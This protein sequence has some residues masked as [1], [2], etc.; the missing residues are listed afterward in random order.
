V[1]GYFAI[2]IFHPKKSVNIGSLW[3]SAS[4]FG[5]SYIFTIGARYSKQ[6]S[7][8]MKTARH[9]P[10]HHYSDFEDFYQ[11]MPHDARVVAVEIADGAR[12]LST[13]QHPERAVYLLGAEDHGLPPSVLERSHHVVRLRGDFCLNVSVA[14]SICMY[15]R[16]TSAG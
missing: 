3:R 8:T 11:H 2:G 16:V 7:D 12:D 14:G 13:F 9:I 15:H 5:A 6:P 1:R 10:L 4:V